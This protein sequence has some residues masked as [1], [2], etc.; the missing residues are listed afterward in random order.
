M[1]PFFLA[2]LM[3]LAVLL[4]HRSLTFPVLGYHSPAC[5]CDTCFEQFAAEYEAD[6]KEGEQ[7]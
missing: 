6:M 1:R 2:V 4:A 7:E 5:L 3:A